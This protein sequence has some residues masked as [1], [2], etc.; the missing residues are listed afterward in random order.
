[1]NKNKKENDVLT[2]NMYCKT[3]HVLTSDC[4]VLNLIRLVIPCKRKTHPSVYLKK[5]LNQEEFYI[6]LQMVRSTF[7]VSSNLSHFKIEKQCGEVFA[8]KVKLSE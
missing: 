6:L 3:I 2:A 5:C 7:L 8:V 4:Q 1:M